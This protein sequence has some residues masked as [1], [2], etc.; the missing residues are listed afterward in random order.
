[1]TGST[2][3]AWV[4]LGANEGEVAVARNV[5]QEL[6]EKHCGRGGREVQEVREGSEPDAFWEALGGR[7]EYPSMAPGEAPPR[8]PR[9]FSASTATGR[10]RVEEV[11]GERGKRGV[12]RK[13]ITSF[14]MHSQ[15]IFIEYFLYL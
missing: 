12:E 1:M 4:G 6:A 15:F 2:A 9:L 11:S 10:F 7:G 14:F 5:A 13:T 8:D 3:F